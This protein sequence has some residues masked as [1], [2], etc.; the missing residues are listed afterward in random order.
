M[1]ITYLYEW[2][3]VVS[4]NTSEVDYF[5]S[6]YRGKQKKDELRSGSEVTFLG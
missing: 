5:E 3:V 4:I 2:S 1:F 6:L